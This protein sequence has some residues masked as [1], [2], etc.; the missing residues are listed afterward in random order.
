MEK[1]LEMLKRDRL[2]KSMML[3]QA[4]LTVQQYLDDLRGFVEHYQFTDKEEEIWFFKVE[5]PRFARWLIFYSELLNIDTTK[6]L[7]I[8]NKLKDH[9]NE[10]IR[11]INR[12]YRTH[13][14]QYQYYRLGTDELDHLFFLRGASSKD[15]RLSS[16]PRVDPSFGTGHEYLFSRFMAFE[17]LQGHLNDLMV[18]QHH[19]LGSRQPANF[20]TG[21]LK[22][23]GES[24]NLIEIV[25]GLYSTGQINNGKTELSEIAEVFQRVFQ[26]NLNRYYRRFVE[27]KQRKGMS[28]TRFLDEM[29]EA[30]RKKI[31]DA[32]GFTTR[33][34]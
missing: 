33:E 19:S 31:D 8:N 10:Q 25:Y 23:T 12:F 14:F 28:K 26:V 6:P 20:D 27:I 13:E 34:G 4:M 30:L 9:Y 5:K 2:S 15:I 7:G 32:N 1:D 21:K 24:L 16:V 11:Y 17:M 18:D 22:W 3:K 29:R